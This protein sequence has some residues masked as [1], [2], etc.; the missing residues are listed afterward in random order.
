LGSIYVKFNWGLVP[1]SIFWSDVRNN[2]TGQKG[3]GLVRLME[4]N[5]STVSHVY[6]FQNTTV[7]EL[8]I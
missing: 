7:N 4:F 3:T 2:D 6:T 1:I 5:L 8:K